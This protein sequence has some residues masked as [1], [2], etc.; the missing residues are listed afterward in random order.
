MN[1]TAIL[2]WVQVVTE[3]GTVLARLMEAGRLF[4]SGHEPTAEELAALKSETDAAIARWQAAAI[5]DRSD[6]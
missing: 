5:Y 1:P 3:L 4:A 6:N 2:A